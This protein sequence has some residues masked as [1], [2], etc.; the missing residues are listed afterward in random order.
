MTKYLLLNDLDCYKRS[1]ILSNLV[2]GFVINWEYFSRNTI[3]SQFVRSV[4]SISA[5]I[6]EG[7]GR[8]NKKDKIKFYHYAMGSQKESLDW[9][10]KAWNRKLITKEQHEHILQE[11]ICLPK[12]INHLIKF[13]REKLKD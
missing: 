8:F 12:D 4:D 10:E 9:N 13:T 2:W 1:F 7:F 6:A 11:L 3:G 5:N